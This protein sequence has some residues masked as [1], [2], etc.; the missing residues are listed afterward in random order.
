MGKSGY[1]MRCRWK[2]IARYGALAGLF[3]LS[4]PTIFGQSP[5][6]VPPPPPDAQQSLPQLS[7]DQLDNL[8][9]PVALYPDP[10]L[11]QVLSASTYPLEVVEANQWLGQNRNLH[12]QQLMDAARQQNWDASVQALVAF[13][14][15]LQM[16]ANNI[17]WATDLGNAFLGQQGDVMAAV[18]RM[19]ARA[20]A[21]G[22]LSNTPQQTVTTQNENG[23]SAIVIQ[24]AARDVIYVPVYSPEYVW[25]PP[26][27][28]YYP[29]LWYPAGF[30]FGFFFGP[31]YFVGGFFPGWVG[32]GGW[33]WGC[34]W[35]HRGLFVNTA[36]FGHYGF[37][38][39]YGG[40]G[41]NGPGYYGRMNWAHNPDHR[42]GVP[43]SN[44][45][46]ASRFGG[47]YGTVT[48]STFAGNAGRWNGGRTAQAPAAPANGG[49]QRFGNNGARGPVT[50]GSTAGRVGSQSFRQSTPQSY[51]QPRAGFNGSASA[52]GPSRSFAQPSYSAP[53]SFSG[54]SSSSAARSYPAPSR[55]Y[56]APPSYSA[57]RSP[58]Y[59]APRSYAAPSRSYSAPSY[60]APRGYGGAPSYSAPR[61]YSYSAPR[62]YSAPSY[63]APRSYGGSMGGGH[64]GGGGGAHFGGGGGGGHHR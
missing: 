39:Y 10:L 34:G 37:H 55:S 61:S 29:P 16:L 4:I 14:D 41:H 5:E 27:W 51:S 20:Q 11:G 25:G 43:Y 28:G 22:R 48:R 7:P 50:S 45:A 32:W 12:G 53:R 9:A 30:G 18:Q 33:G 56:S 47:T 24:P 52:A 38:G 58:S 17:R 6:E 35:F 54:N 57:P 59:S 8:V 63:S 26:A 23:Q 40:Y 1:I 36:F 15:A 46:V 13:P 21:N 42:M 49:W 60:S 3:A 64:Y 62:S 19:R 44:R 2:E 31:P